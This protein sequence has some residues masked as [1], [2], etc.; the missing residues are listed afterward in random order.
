M[1][2]SLPGSSFCD[3]LFLVHQYS[4][5]HSSFSLPHFA[6][7]LCH[8]HRDYGHSSARDDCSSRG[9]CDRDGYGGGRDRD[10]ADHPS[11]GSYRDP[12]ESY[13][14]ARGPPP[15]YGGGRYEEY[16]GCS[17]DGYGGGREGYGGG[18]SDAILEAQIHK[19]FCAV[20]LF[21]FLVPGIETKVLN[22]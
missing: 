18:R 14:D 21:C 2:P 6:A 15:S 4:H 22:H 19:F 7:I 10:Y 13:G 5:L 20:V 3:A 1:S 12:F 16:R 11:R 17:P 9:Y 8:G